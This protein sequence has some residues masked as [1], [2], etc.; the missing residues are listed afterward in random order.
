MNC[1]R[2]KIINSSGAF[3][4]I[5]LLAAVVILGFM[6]VS[7]MHLYS[8]GSNMNF[9]T[10]ENL[11]A[12]NLIQYKAEEIKAQP[13][14]KN[15]SIT[16]QTISGFTKY[17]IDVT[18]TVPYSG[19]AFLKKIRIICTYSSAVGVTRQEKMDFLIANNS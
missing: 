17:R 8:F 7:I 9:L 4:L 5:E 12:A 16:G 3:S 19:N 15:V 6:A 18:Q 11:V 1:K 13:F 10:E 2:I 14:V